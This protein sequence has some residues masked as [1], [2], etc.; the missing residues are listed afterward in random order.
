MMAQGSIDTGLA[1][2]APEQTPT[3]EPS[4]L[5][6][7]YRVCLWIA[8]AA[9][10]ALLIGDAL[11]LSAVHDFRQVLAHYGAG[12]APP[13]ELPDLDMFMGVGA[14]F[15]I[16][17]FLL[18]LSTFFLAMARARR[19]AKAVGIEGFDHSIG[20]TIGT[21]FIPILNLYR[22][23]IGLAEIRNA[24]V[25]SSRFRQSGDEWKNHEGP[26]G[27]TWALGAAAIVL[28]AVSRQF[29][30]SKLPDPQSAGEVGPWIDAQWNLT[31]IG[32]AIELVWAIA[33]IVYLR[34]LYG[35]LKQLIAMHLDGEL[36]SAR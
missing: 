3:V 29:D 11:P 5:I 25:L 10:L 36:K 32:S 24:V 17:G 2:G 9:V 12:N 23:W 19:I 6:R 20:W 7:R 4:G 14:L 34:A 31:L 1:A 21:F 26:T 16:L 13:E 15:T 22:P 8:I 33:F 28:P 30:T 35:P 27:A 18:I